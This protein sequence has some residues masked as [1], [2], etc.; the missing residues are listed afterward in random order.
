VRA[1]LL[2]P[3]WSGLSARVAGGIAFCKEVFRRSISELEGTLLGGESTPAAAFL[4]LWLEDDVLMEWRETPEEA[5][6]EVELLEDRSPPRVS[7]KADCSSRRAWVLVVDTSGLGARQGWTESLRR[8]NMPPDGLG[9][10]LGGVRPE[11]P[12]RDTL[13]A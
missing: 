1:L 13:E 8:G 7:I 9:G 3:A 5:L 2:G 12:R 11:T 10:T 4:R 6:D